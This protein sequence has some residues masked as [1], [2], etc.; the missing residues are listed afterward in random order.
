MKNLLIKRGLFD[1]QQNPTPF[2]KQGFFNLNKWIKKILN[3]LH[4]THVDSCCPNEGVTTLR[5]DSTGESIQSY[6]PNTNTWEDVVTGGGG[7]STLQAI[8]TDPDSNITTSAIQSTGVENLDNTE[9]STALYNYASLAESGGMGYT[10]GTTLR[11]MIEYS[12]TNEETI[13]FN[14]AQNQSILLREEDF[15]NAGIVV[16]ARIKGFDANVDEE[17]TTL[18]QVEK[19]VY[20]QQADWV[21]NDTFTA[22]PGY[23]I[24]YM[25]SGDGTALVPVP[26]AANSI[27]KSIRITNYVNFNLTLTPIT[28]TNNFITN[29]TQAD[30]LVLTQWKSVLMYSNGQHWIITPTS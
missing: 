19:M 27:G 24:N 3:Y 15:N 10:N 1:E 4:I 13:I 7:G 26:S 29:G 5:Y 8:T 30:T 18:G 23:S 22:F 11:R 17:L 2:E 12:E 16:S 6:N 25:F 14:D 20:L 9:Q 21:I 28:G